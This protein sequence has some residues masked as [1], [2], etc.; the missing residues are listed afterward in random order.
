[1]S[2]RTAGC[3]DTWDGRKRPGKT[4]G[5]GRNRIRRGANVVD[6]GRLA[7]VNRADLGVMDT[8]FF[9]DRADWGDEYRRHCV[10]VDRDW[11]GYPASGNSARDRPHHMLGK[12]DSWSRRIRPILARFESGR[13]A[14]QVSASK[15]SALGRCLSVLLSGSPSK[16]GL[17]SENSRGEARSA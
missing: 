13:L 3:P 4:D 8:M 1:M 16:I 11:F 15:V 2:W 17:P 14:R 5:V 9:A 10:V 7:I 12:S 6:P